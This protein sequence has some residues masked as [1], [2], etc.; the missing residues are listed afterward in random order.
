MFIDASQYRVSSIEHQ[1]SAQNVNGAHEQ[2]EVGPEEEDL[3]D[4]SDP[5]PPH[6]QTS[7][8]KFTDF[9][10]QQTAKTNGP[11]TDKRSSG[12]STFYDMDPLNSLF[13]DSNSPSTSSS[14]R[15]SNRQSNGSYELRLTKF[16]E[17]PKFPENKQQ[18]GTS[19][20]SNWTKFE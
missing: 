2:E 14:N 16:P 17:P 5:S 6:Q 7:D 20:F 1:D 9:F 3:I 15:S 11:V 19:G 4:F 13:V 12:G 18:K 10:K 8:D